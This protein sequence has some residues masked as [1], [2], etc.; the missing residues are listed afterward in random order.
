MKPEEITDLHNLCKV[1]AELKKQMIEELPHF[2]SEALYF[3][4][5]E[6]TTGLLDNKIEIKINLRANRLQ[7]FNNEQGFSIDL[8]AGNASQQLQQ[9]TSDHDLKF[10]NI[11]VDKVPQNQ[12]SLFLNYAINAARTLEL[13]RMELQGKFT[14]V[15]LWP[16]H[17]DFSVEW[18]TGN[19][20]EQIGTGISPGDENNSEPYLYM[21]PYPF[22]YK[23]LEQSLPLGKWHTEGWKGVKIEW[24]E[25]LKYTPTNA[26]EKLSKVFEIVKR[27]FD[28]EMVK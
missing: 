2:G 1:I 22:N 3:K 9:I 4:S 18:F 25:L 14:L 28:L 11:T 26:S 19:T 7:Y 6:I 15:H 12:S 10:P 5:D 24:S 20:D 16:D 23:V 21:N 13:F 17:F 8:N 27:N